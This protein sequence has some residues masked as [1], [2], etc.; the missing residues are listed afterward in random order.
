MRL[1]SSFPRSFQHTTFRF[2]FKSTSE[3]RYKRFLVSFKRVKLG[4][5]RVKVWQ[6]MA[7]NLKKVQLEINEQFSSTRQK[8]FPETA[9]FVVLNSSHQ[10]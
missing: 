9:R 6:L 10:K 2:P 4:Q 5:V 7:G 8:A 1:S 3:T